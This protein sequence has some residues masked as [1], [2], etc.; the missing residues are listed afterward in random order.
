M[1]G[2]DRASKT[3]IKVVICGVSGREVDKKWALSLKSGSATCGRVA[4]PTSH[5]QD[6]ASGARFCGG[7]DGGDAGGGG[8]HGAGAA[9]GHG[10]GGGAGGGAGLLD[11]GAD[12]GG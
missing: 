2:T 5:G 8:G 4:R 12:A 1:I 7:G 11:A 6:G 3:G 9:G 10:G